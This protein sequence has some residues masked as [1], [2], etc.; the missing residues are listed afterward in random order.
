M[1]TR[2]GTLGTEAG[3]VFLNEWSKDYVEQNRYGSLFQQAFNSPNFLETE[4]HRKVSNTLKSGSV[5]QATTMKRGKVP[6]VRVAFQV[7]PT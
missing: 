6:P 2:P 4:S 7:Y 3:T 1:N 5:M